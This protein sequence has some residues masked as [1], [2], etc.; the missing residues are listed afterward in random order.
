MQLA[1]YLSNTMPGSREGPILGYE[2]E[3]VHHPSELMDHMEQVHHWDKGWT[4]I[5]V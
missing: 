4:K 2:C 3:H 1:P 5:L